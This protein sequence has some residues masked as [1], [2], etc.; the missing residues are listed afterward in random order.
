M[1]STACCSSV[2]IDVVEAGGT[3]RNNPCAAGSKLFQHIAVDGVVDEDADGRKPAA[4]NAVPD[5]R[6]VSK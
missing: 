2:Y 4:R 6:G 5:P 1:T 3:R